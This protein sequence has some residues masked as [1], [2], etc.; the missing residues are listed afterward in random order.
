VARGENIKNKIQKYKSTLDS[1]FGHE[2][3][4]F[5]LKWYIGAVI[6]LVLEQVVENIAADVGQEERLEWKG[7]PQ[8]F[9]RDKMAGDQACTEWGPPRA[10]PPHAHILDKHTK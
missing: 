7:A 9:D 2:A 4:A 3:A 10:H 6:A 5:T 1:F 8:Y